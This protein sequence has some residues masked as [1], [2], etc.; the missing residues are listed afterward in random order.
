MLTGEVLALLAAMA[1]GLAGIA[2]NKGKLCANGDNG[3]FLSVLLTALLSFL[4][5]MAWGKVPAAALMR[6]ESFPAIIVFVLAGLASTVLGRITMYR[7]TELSGAVVASMLRRLTPVFAL[8]LG[9]V[10]LAEFPDIP[11]LVGGSLILLGVIL[12]LCAEG[13][14]VV[15]DSR[16]GLALGAGSAFFYAIAYTLRGAGLDSLPDPALGTLIGAMAG[17]AWFVLRPVFCGRRRQMVVRLFCDHGKWHLVGALMLTTGQLLQFFA[18][19]SASVVTVAVLGS[20]EVLFAAALGAALIGP[21]VSG[22]APFLVSV[23][24]AITGTALLF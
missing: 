20:L 4:L 8:P 2:I 16:V 21:Q 5:W 14:R 18:L 3:V 9:L 19:Q 23:L 11:T 10:V 6:P 12:F 1:Y 13:C 17:L 22:S 7:A 24:L 15:F